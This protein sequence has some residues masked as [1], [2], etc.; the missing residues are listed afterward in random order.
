MT[1]QLRLSKPNMGSIKILSRQ[2]KDIIAKAAEE[3]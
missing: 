2:L 1:K 3:T